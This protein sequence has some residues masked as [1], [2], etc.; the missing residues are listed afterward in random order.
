MQ[1]EFT[2]EGE[3]Q[4]SR[5]LGIVADGIKDF[6]PAFQLSASELIRVYKSNFSAR[7]TLLGEPWQERKP[8]YRNGARVDDW[9]LLQETGAMRQGFEAQVDA[10]SMVIFNIMDYFKYHQSNQP[11]SSQ[12]PRRVMMK[13]VE[14]QRRFIVKAMQKYIVDL[15]TKA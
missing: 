1:L 7:G 3:K 8:Q 15:R 14:A 4:L 6:K 2:L 9:P 13:L 10:T 11:R 5:R 12:L